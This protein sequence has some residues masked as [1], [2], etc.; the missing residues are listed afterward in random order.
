MDHISEEKK[1]IPSSENLSTPIVSLAPELLCSIFS[2]CVS[3]DQ[4]KDARSSDSIRCSFR[5]PL[6]LGRVCSRWRDVTISSPKL[7]SSCAVGA[8]RDPPETDL[9]K[10]LEATKHW[11][12]SMER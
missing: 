10:D 7:W 12:S 9:A 11:I 3:N 2:H 8:D 4:P 5:A 6:L 1:E